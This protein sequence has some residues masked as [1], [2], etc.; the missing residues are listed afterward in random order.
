MRHRSILAGTLVLGLLCSMGL[1]AQQSD[2][3][4]SNNTPLAAS[5]QSAAGTVPRLIKFTGR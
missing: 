1:A 5:S 3:S 4:A 2:S